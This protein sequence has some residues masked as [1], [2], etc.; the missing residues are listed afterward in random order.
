MLKGEEFLF[1]L[2]GSGERQE[3]HVLLLIFLVVLGCL[4]KA[5]RPEEGT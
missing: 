2:L 5:L 1:F 4:P 3:Y